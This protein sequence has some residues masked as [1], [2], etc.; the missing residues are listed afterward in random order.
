MHWTALLEKNKVPATARVR[1]DLPCGGC[2]YNLRHAF[3]A[4]RCPECA[5]PIIES[6][7]PFDDPHETANTVDG[8][9]TSFF[10]LF[11]IYGVALLT[12]LVGS[13]HGF[14][15]M[16]LV[17]GGLHLLGA[18]IRAARIHTLIRRRD[19]RAV[20]APNPILRIAVVVAIIDAVL[21]VPALLSIYL[22][23]RAQVMGMIVF[24]DTRLLFCAA[25]FAVTH[26]ALTIWTRAVH[27]AGRQL[28]YDIIV[29]EGTIQRTTYIAAGI[30]VTACI[31]FRAVG[32]PSLAAAGMVFTTMLLLAGTLTAAISTFHLGNAIRAEVEM[33]DDLIDVERTS[34]LDEKRGSEAPETPPTDIQVDGVP[35]A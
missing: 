13:S 16:A 12:F 20:H 24:N 34:Y 23:A 35:P 21:I 25:S 27:A 33:N 17:A 26:V 9:G 1:D 18:C 31:V 7:V 28:E 14:S 22:H 19:F 15:L 4:G 3:A 10:A 11:P 8:V 32:Q 5:R 30:G 6:L 2:G 29:R